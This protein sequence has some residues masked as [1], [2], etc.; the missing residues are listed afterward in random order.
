MSFR[1]TEAIKKRIVNK[2]GYKCNGIADYICPLNGNVFDE[3]G[4]DIDHI[5]PISQGGS[6][7][8][9]NLQ[10]LCTCCHRVKTKREKSKVNTRELHVKLEKLKTENTKIKIEKMDKDKLEKE[11]DIL[12]KEKNIL[13]KYKDILDKEKIE[14]ELKLKSEIK[15]KNEMKTQ[16]DEKNAEIEKLKNNIQKQQEKIKR[17]QNKKIDIFRQIE[18]KLFPLIK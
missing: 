12:E 8:D 16:A 1:I 15:L 4:Y 18:K 3:S 14:F 10:A 9:C 11:K 17:Q 5:L 13:E 6:S 7:D 2:Q